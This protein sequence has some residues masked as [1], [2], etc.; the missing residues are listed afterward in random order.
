MSDKHEMLLMHAYQ[1]ENTIFL[2]DGKR[3]VKLRRWGWFMSE[4]CDNKKMFF[5]FFYQYFR[6]QFL[7]LL[8]FIVILT[9]GHEQKDDQTKGFE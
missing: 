7:L 9:W 2:I 4:F 6:W 8:I 5:S 1:N 3:A